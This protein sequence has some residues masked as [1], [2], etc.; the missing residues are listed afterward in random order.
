MSLNH[1]LIIISA[2]LFGLLGVYLLMGKKKSRPNAYLGI[3]FLLWSVNFFDGF[4]L[5]TGIYFDY[6]HLAVWEDALIFWHGPMIYAYV[7]Q[8]TRRKHLSGWWF[9]LNAIPFLLA[10]WLS[11]VFYHLEPEETRKM[12]LQS[13]TRPHQPLAII[14]PLLVTFIHMSGYIVASK[15]LL[16]QY[17]KL[18]QSY[19]SSNHIGWFNHN[20]NWIISILMLSLTVS[21]IQYLNWQPLMQA[22]LLVLNL[23]ILG[24]IV[25]IW[26][27]TMDEPKLLTYQKYSAS[28][29]NIDELEAVARQIAEVV[30]GNKLYLNPELTLDDVATAVNRDNRIISQ[31]INTIFGKNFF[32]YINALRIEE[33]KCKFEES[34]DD[35]LTILEV[36]YAVGFN[37]KSSFNTQ[38]KKK[39]GLT[40]SQYR[41]KVR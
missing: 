24:F 16:I 27:Q 18:Q 19:Y 5:M 10:L 7:N 1:I 3:F 36:M 39:T 34:T 17:H 25:R 20:L 9:L 15:R 4:L 23:A 13:I 12:I 32:D 26:F 40:P 37:S 14:I 2:S 22:G 41:S 29:G 8:L 38:F 11:I 21:F 35:K 6:S 30:E 33:A 31:A 28:T